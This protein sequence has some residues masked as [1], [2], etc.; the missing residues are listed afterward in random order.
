MAIFAEISP[1]D[2]F[3]NKITQLYSMTTHNYYNSKMV[4][5]FSYYN[6]SKER[7][8]ICKPLFQE[9]KENFISIGIS[10]DAVFSDRRDIL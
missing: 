2:Y 5:I 10:I 1:N 7:N 3:S 6:K 9:D 8:E 4:N